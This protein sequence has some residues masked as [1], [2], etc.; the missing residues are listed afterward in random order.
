MQTHLRLYRRVL[1]AACMLILRIGQVSLLRAQDA[2]TAKLTGTVLDQHG[3]AIAKATVEVKSESS[4]RVLKVTTGSDGRFVAESLAA[5]AYT[6]EVSAVGFSTQVRQNVQ[7]S[8]TDANEI[9]IPLGIG[10][11]LEEVTVTADGNSSIASQLSPVKALLIERSATSVITSNFIQNFTSPVA[12]YGELVQMVPGA[13]TISADGVGMGQ[14]KTYFRG[15][16]D[17]DYDIDFDGIPFYDTNSPTHHSWAFFP[18]QWVGGVNFDRSPGSAATTGP[19]P[20]GGSIHLLS[21]EMPSQFNVR[22][23]VIY[24]S[25]NTQLYDGAMDTGN[26]G[27]GGRQNVIVDVHHM[28]S[29]GYQTYN[30]HERNAG[31][32]KYQF[33]ISDHTVLT[34]YSGVVILDSNTPNFNGPQF[35]VDHLRRQFPAHQQRQSHL[36]F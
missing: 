23:N 11:Q 9:S 14:S 35:A 1:T 26:F 30:Y 4:K 24:G 21:K 32:L 13:F 5:G 6:I 18:S 2:G 15:F 22:A 8:I 36:L 34:G 3:S 19:T 16:P 7:V 25:W 33:R 31:K 29:D 17:G 27:P 28:T 12:D 20:F 10:R